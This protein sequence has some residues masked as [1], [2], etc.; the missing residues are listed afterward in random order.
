MK[1]TKEGK[2]PEPIIPK[3]GIFFKG[4]CKNCNCEFEAHEKEFFEKVEE[5]FRSDM[6]I[7]GGQD[8][9]RDTNLYVNCPTCNKEIKVKTINTKYGHKA[10]LDN[11]VYWF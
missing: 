7:Y 1:I 11:E 2:I 9:T 4:K 5:D 3:F 6:T 8:W 10:A